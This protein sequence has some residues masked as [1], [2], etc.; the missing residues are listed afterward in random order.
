MAPGCERSRPVVAGP[1]GAYAVALRSMHGGLCPVS[2]APSPVSRAPCPCPRPR[3]TCSAFRVLRPA[4]HARVFR[5]LHFVPPFPV[6]C[7]PRPVARVLR[8]AFCVLRSAFCVLRPASCTPCPRARARVRVRV[9]VHVFRVLRPA[10]HARVF[11][12]PHPRPAPRTRTRGPAPCARA[13]APVSRAPH[14]VPVAP[15]S[16]SR[17]RLPAFRALSPPTH[18]LRG[19]SFRLLQAA[20]M[21]RKSGGSPEE[22]PDFACIA[23]ARLTRACG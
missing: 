18:T 22:P 15:S 7:C 5:L 3:F 19:R 17:G 2:C 4:P 14:P 21:K 8:P 23:A 10:P 12:V 1:G 13:R 11:R 9:H 20:G 16:A 6:F